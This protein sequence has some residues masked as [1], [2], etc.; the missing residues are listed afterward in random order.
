MAGSALPILAGGAAL[1]LFSGGKKK[2]KISGPT[3]WGVRV[4]PDCK[5]ITIVN[6]ELFQKFLIGAFDELVQTDPTLGILQLT[7]ALFGDVA[8]NCSGFPEEPESPAVAELYATIAR[9]MARL[10][11]EDPRVSASDT[12]LVDET[13]QIA[14]ADW[15]RGWRNYPSSEVMHVPEE[16][17]SFSADYTNYEIGPKWY[18]KTIRPE[19]TAALHEGRIDSLYEFVVERRG[20]LVGRFVTP[21]SELP[22]GKPAVEEFLDK[23]EENI[24]RAVVE[25]S[26]GGP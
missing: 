19:A 25:V 23:L 5:E 1:I 3:R 14:F 16:Q 21:I 17:V 2:R 9:T 13:T 11:I 7:D 20:V 12:D 6:P 22:E 18:E 4:T 8:P 26:G 24:E 15:Y 10:M